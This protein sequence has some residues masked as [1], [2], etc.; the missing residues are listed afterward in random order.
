VQRGIIVVDDEI[1]NAVRYKYQ[2]AKRTKP[3][4]DIIVSPGGPRQ[5]TQEQFDKNPALTQG[6]VTDTGGANDAGTQAGA[7]SSV[8]PAPEEPKWLGR[9]MDK[10]TASLPFANATPAVQ[11]TGEKK[12]TRTIVK[13][14][15]NGDLETTYLYEDEE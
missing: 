3:R 6:E 8:V 1:E 14:L 2:L 4:G 11:Q 15:D 12:P 9:L 13:K 10:L 7:P 5:P